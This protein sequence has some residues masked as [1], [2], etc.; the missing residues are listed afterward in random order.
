MAVFYAKTMD[1]KCLDA[2]E[3]EII[4][5]LYIWYNANRNLVGQ[6]GASQVYYATII[7]AFPFIFASFNYFC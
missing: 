7:L 1:K 3:A 4:G 6:F 2:R 5:Q